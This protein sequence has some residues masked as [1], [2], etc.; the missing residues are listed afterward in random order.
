LPPINKEIM[1]KR[2][3]HNQSIMPE[4]IRTSGDENAAGLLSHDD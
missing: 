2:Y 4:A 1:L 3:L